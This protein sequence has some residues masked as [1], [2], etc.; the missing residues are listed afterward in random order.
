VL[1]IEC[2]RLKIAAISDLHVLPD[3]GDRELLESIR[4]RVEE[5]DPDVFVIAGDI[6]DRIKVLSDSL[7]LLK[8]DSCTNL[9]V[10]GN[11]DIW[12]E[13]GESPT[14]LEKYSKYIGQICKKQGFHHLPDGPYTIEDFAFVG[15]IGWYDYSFRRPELEIPMKNYE[16]KEYR[17]AVWYDLFKVDW[18]YRDLEATS[19]FN[20]K[21]EYDL[22]TLPDE[23]E[24]VVYVSHHLPFCELTL[25]KDRLPW[26]FHSAFMGAQST[27]EILVNDGRVVLSISGHS[28]IRN[29]IS[30][31]GI[32]A[33]VV[34]LGYGR[35]DRNNIDTIVRKA[36]AT[37][38]IS[39]DGVDVPDFVTGD[40]CEDLSYI[41]SR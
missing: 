41:S 27:G 19:L 3:E 30:I 26:D 6:S 17:G 8:V 13:E 15:S 10:A 39:K 35:P 21:L 40:I 16:Q 29:K 36:V 24:H 38:E 2:G 34:P 14:S 1:E 32:T 23:V 28:H 22:S 12:F 33:L 4:R 31:E 5:I 7:S 18:N 37:I 9:Y 20:Q 11:H 25:Y